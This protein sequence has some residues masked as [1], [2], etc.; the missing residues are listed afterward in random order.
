M[1]LIDFKQE[2]MIQKILFTI[3]I[4][5]LS[6]NICFAQQDGQRRK[7]D[8]LELPAY[9]NKFSLQVIYHSAYTTS[10]D[11]KHK[12]PNWVAWKLLGSNVENKKVSREDYNS[13]SP[14][15]NVFDGPD[16]N[17]YKYSGYD[18]GHMCPAADNAW[19]L[20]IYKES[21][22][23]TNICP[24][25]P[26]LNQKSWDRL[27]NRCRNWAKKHKEI[28]IVCGPIIPK[29]VTRRIGDITIPR[30]FFKA[31]MRIEKGN[32]HMIGY[33]FNQNGKWKIL[34]I[35]DIERITELDLF[36]NI[37]DHIEA[38]VEAIVDTS[39]WEHYDR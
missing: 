37:P 5:I 1:G 28:Y 32:Y 20:N 33:L 15:P 13:F 16:A 4:V 14:D 24:Q 10:Y 18:R 6:F 39:K 25:T 12:I 38:K 3:I 31:I 17:N 30:D 8:M 22:Y 11:K 36:H 29:R 27:E 2:Y 23:M 21:F 19:D 34:S 26:E 35:D 7:T 9:S